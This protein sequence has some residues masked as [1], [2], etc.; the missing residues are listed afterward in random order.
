MSYCL[1]SLQTIEMEL[2]KEGVLLKGE[3]MVLFWDCKRGNIFLC[4]AT[5]Q[6]EGILL[7]LIF[8]VGEKGANICNWEGVGVGWGDMFLLLLFSVDIYT[9]VRLI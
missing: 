4:W 6:Y 2:A 1:A 5:M 7:V 9:E 8:C 3:M